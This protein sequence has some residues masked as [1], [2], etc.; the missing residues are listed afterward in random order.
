MAQ[1]TLIEDSTGEFPTINLV[2]SNWIF[3][4]VQIHQGP[5][6]SNEAP[7]IDSRMERDVISMHKEQA[8]QLAR[9][10]LKYYE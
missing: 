2:T 9:A 8:L 3:H 4:E 10:I 6:L 5:A 7:M 1:Q